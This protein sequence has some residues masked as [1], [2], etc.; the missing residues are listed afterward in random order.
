MIVTDYLRLLRPSV[1]KQFSPQL[2]K[3]VNELS[4]FDKQNKEILGQLFVQGGLARTKEGQDGLMRA[5]VRIPPG[6]LIWN[7]AIIA[8][9]RA[10][11]LEVEVVNDDPYIY[12][13]AVFPSNGDK[14]WLW[15]PIY[16]RG[17]A[18]INL[19]GPGFYWFGSPPKNDTGR[20][21]LG[22]ILVQGEVPEE[23]RLDRPKQPRP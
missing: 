16:S 17:K 20:G 1:L 14:Q 12:H 13:A 5:H 11:E 22:L 8:M 6:K 19:D 23:A 2:V 21:M 15:L 9:P 10:G 3:L 18:R 7:P 4:G